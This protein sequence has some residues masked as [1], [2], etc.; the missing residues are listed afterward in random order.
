MGTTIYLSKATGTAFEERGARGGTITSL[1]T[2]YV[3]SYVPDDGQVRR[4]ERA[5]IGP[6]ENEVSKLVSRCH[7]TAPAPFLSRG[8]GRF[9]KA[10]RS[11]TDG[12]GGPTSAPQLADYTKPMKGGL[13]DLRF[14]AGRDRGA[15]FDKLRVTTA[16]ALRDQRSWAPFWTESSQRYPSGS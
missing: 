11:Y 14:C 13:R 3:I 5:G 6:A 1:D 10:M 4:L 15:P 12:N 9:G 7:R 16:G 2:G 8:A